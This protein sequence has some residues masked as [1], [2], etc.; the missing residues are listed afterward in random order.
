MKNIERTLKALAN[1]RRLEILRMLQKNKEMA[2]SDIAGALKLSV[3]ATSKHLTILFSVDILER[4]QRRLKVHY[5]IV[6]SRAQSSTVRAI[7]SML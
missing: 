4:E 3:K 7:L 1:R 6:T 5:R 2:V